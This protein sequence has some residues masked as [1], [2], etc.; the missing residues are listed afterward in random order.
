MNWFRK[1]KDRRA[2]DR[3][4]MEKS[5]ALLHETVRTT[6]EVNERHRQALEQ[7]SEATYQAGQLADTDR[8]NH[9]SESLTYAF[10]GR[11]A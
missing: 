5:K 10:R 3:V 1:V 7:L 2:E 11:T 4:A 9:Y 6:P 8:Q